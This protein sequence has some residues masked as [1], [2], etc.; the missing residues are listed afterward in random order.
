MIQDF[1]LGCDTACQDRIC[2]GFCVFGS[3]VEQVRLLGVSGMML[4]AVL[5]G[6]GAVNSTYNYFNFFSL[7]LS[8]GDLDILEEQCL[9]NERQL[10]ELR[11][12]Q[13]PV[14]P[15]SSGMWSWATGKIDPNQEYLDA[16]I[17]ALEA[18]HQEYAE[19]E[20]LCRYPRCDR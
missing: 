4:S 3:L 13:R 12:K 17:R 5:S 2:P 20:G 11:A 10:N 15:S 18:V 16:E 8:H 7:E 14:N 9:M 1:I 19:S 6:F